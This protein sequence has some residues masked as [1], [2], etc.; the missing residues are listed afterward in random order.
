MS[1]TSISRRNIFPAGFGLALSG[2]AV[3]A[4]AAEEGASAEE[5]ANIKYVNEFLAA[6]GPGGAPGKDVAIKYMAAD[7]MFRIYG[8]PQP[9]EMQ[10]RLFLKTRWINR[11]SALKSKCWKLSRRGAW[12][13][14]IAAKSSLPKANPALCSTMVLSFSSKITKLKN[15]PNL[16]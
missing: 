5:K 8:R 9:P 16:L 11:A 7:S 15:G 13:R 2:V 10:Y 1:S 4:E 3:S 14:I 12:W 6:F